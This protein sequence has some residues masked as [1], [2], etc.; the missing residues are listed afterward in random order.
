DKL[1][2]DLKKYTG[3]FKDDWFGDVLISEKKG[4][5]YFNSKRSKALAGEIFYYKDNTLVVKWNTRSFNADAFL[6]YELDK[7]GNLNILKMKAISEL[8]DFSYDF[9]DLNFIKVVL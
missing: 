7:N 4:K 8:T 1:K 2:I 3:T 5:L 6:S 9:Q